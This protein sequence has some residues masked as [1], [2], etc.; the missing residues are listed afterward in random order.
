MRDKASRCSGAVLAFFLISFVCALGTNAQKSYKELKF[1]P[2]RKF[3]IPEA[4]RVELDNGMIL[5]LIEDH[6]LP[7]VEASMLIGV[8]SIYEPADK[9]GLASITGTVIRT[10][11]SYSRSGDQIDEELE[12]IGGSVEVSIRRTTG[13]ASVSVLKEYADLAFDILADIL[14]NPAFPEDKIELA[15]IEQRSAIARRNDSPMQIINR[16]FYKLI[17]GPDSPYARHPEYATIDNITRDDLIAF[18]RRY[19]HPNNFILGIWGDF[20]TDD[21]IELVKKHFADWPRARIERPSLPPVKY[22][23]DYSV[24]YIE[25]TDLTQSYIMLGHIGGIR[26]NPDYFTWRV[27]NQILGG[28]FTSRL[29]RIVRSRMGLA[30]SVFGAY[31]ANYDYP[32]VFYVGCQTKLETTVKAIRAMLEQVERMREEEVTDEELTQAKESLLNSFVFNFDTKE[33]VVRRLMTYEY[34]G[35]PKDFLQ[36]LRDAVERVTKADIKRVARKYLRPDKVRILVLGNQEKFDQP[37]STLGEVRTIDITIPEPA[38][39]TEGAAQ[40]ESR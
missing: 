20:N 17:Y 39:A 37:L 34:Y 27:M 18:H 2:L 38:A 21:M 28:A 24:N 13:N 11:G 1:P 15:K 33:E 25:K 22:E 32:G 4:K 9:I 5:F 12:R 29:F 30:Y 26:R 23:F 31:G 10:G 3:E 36:R 6:E 35:Y 19:F 7:L 8:G 40:G 16:E 14:R